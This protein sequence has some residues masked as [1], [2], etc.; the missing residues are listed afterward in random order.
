MMGAHQEIALLE[1]RNPQWKDLASEW[2]QWM[3]TTKG[4]DASTPLSMTIYS[5]VLLR[6][7]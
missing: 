4:R 3:E 7:A 5:V 2:Y 1:R 6:S